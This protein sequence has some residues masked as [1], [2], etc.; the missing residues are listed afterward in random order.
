MIGTITVLKKGKP[1]V[2]I[3]WRNIEFITE[4][5]EQYSMATPLT[6]VTTKNQLTYDEKKAGWELLWD[7]KTTTGWRGA[8]LDAFPEEG[9]EINDGILSVLAS[10]GGESTAG[11][12]IVTEKMY[13]NFEMKVDFKITTLMPN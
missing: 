7:G 4:N 9:W 8:K 13:A 5:L 1:G 10:G 6:P 11:G 2:E 3:K 12:D